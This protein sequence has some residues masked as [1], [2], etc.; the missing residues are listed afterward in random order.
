MFL[1]KLRKSNSTTKKFQDRKILKPLLRKTRKTLKFLRID[2]SNRTNA[3]IVSKMNLE[4]EIRESWIM[5][6][7]L[8][9]FDF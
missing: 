3:R 4:R 5:E 9:N 7:A 6:I 2:V 1:E 8:T